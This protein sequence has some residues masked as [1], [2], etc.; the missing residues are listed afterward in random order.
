[1]YLH[2][3]CIKFYYGERINRKDI[4]VFNFLLSILTSPS[5]GVSVCLRIPP[6]LP[7]TILNFGLTL[8]S[9]HVLQLRAKD[10]GENKLFRPARN[11][12]AGSFAHLQPRWTIVTEEYVYLFFLWSSVQQYLI[13][14][15]DQRRKFN[16]DVA[17]VLVLSL[18]LCLLSS[19]SVSQPRTVSICKSTHNSAK[20]YRTGPV[21]LAACIL[22]SPRTVLLPF[23][24]PLCTSSI[25]T[26]SRRSFGDGNRRK[27]HAFG[28]ITTGCVLSMRKTK[29]LPSKPL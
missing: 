18:P 11:L 2:V 20:T 9:C 13:P 8:P 10:V 27:L 19:K 28:K 6:P 5:P 1:M 29:Q 23:C 22:V 3:S 17:Y 21:F 24:P 4:F 14:K 12:L 7:P 26:V 16:S 15:S 25:R